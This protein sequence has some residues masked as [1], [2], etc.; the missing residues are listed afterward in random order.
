MYNVIYGKKKHG[1]GEEKK[2][3]FQKDEK[4]ISDKSGDVGEEGEKEKIAFD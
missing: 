1:G 4:A 2:I 3:P